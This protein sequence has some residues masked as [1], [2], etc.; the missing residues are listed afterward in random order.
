MIR[1][2]EQFDDKLNQH[3][4]DEFKTDLDNLFKPLH[5]VPPEIDRAILDKASNKFLRRQKRFRIIRR[6]GTIATTAAVILFAFS[7]DLSKKPKSQAPPAYLAQTVS[8]DIDKSGHVDIL[9][10]FKLARHIE[11]NNNIESNYD[12]NGDGIINRDDVDSIAL[13][14]VRLD[15]GVL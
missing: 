5:S 7:L 11:S 15:K 8:Y 13:A 12:I 2:N 10:A 9:D 4:S 1:K 3:V 14:A 6:I